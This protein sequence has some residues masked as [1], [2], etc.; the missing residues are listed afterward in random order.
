[1]SKKIPAV[2]E[3]DSAITIW[4][5]SVNSS[6][7]WESDIYLPRHVTLSAREI[8]RRTERERQARAREARGDLQP[9]GMLSAPPVDY[10]KLADT[11]AFFVDEA[12]LT[13]GEGIHSTLGEIVWVRPDECVDAGQVAARPALVVY[14]TNRHSLADRMEIVPNVASGDPLLRHIEL[15]LE[16]E[17]NAQTP[18][19]HLYAESL[20]NALALHFVKRYRVANQGLQR[21]AGGL[22]PYRLRRV[23]LYINEH[24]DQDLS[25]VR[26]GGIAETSAAHFSRLFKQATGS[27]PH[28]YVL[29]C[30]ID[31]AKALLTTTD[32]PIGEVAQRVGCTDQSHLTALFR[33][34]VATTPRAFRNSSTV[35][36]KVGF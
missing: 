31:R 1:M 34:R 18:D 25:L 27:T 24:L 26:L 23:L 14:A 32:M 35:D 12:A 2:I 21:A 29:A 22:P 5:K 9:M 10:Q 20:A 19:S 6:T 11:F 17:F 30:R 33:A 3:R 16:T 15:V 28:H 8:R 7:R 4:L 13:G 36:R